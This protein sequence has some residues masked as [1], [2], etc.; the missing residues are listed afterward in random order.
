MS[1]TYSS[2]T[3]FMTESMPKCAVLLVDDDPQVLAVI[4]EMLTR[5][6]CEVK[7]TR[8]PDQAVLILQDLSLP[9][10]LLV[11]D[12]SMKR[13]NGSEL[14]RAAFRFRP[15]LRALFMSGDPACISR[16]RSADPFLLKPFTTAELKDKLSLV[17]RDLP[18]T[19]DLKTRLDFDL[20]IDKESRARMVSPTRFGPSD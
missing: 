10:D 18:L 17:L 12:F 13:M 2:S 5:L 11:T 16:F 14:A 15:R 6:G 7:K 3:D 8:G 1:D 19:S 9:L 20:W 4:S